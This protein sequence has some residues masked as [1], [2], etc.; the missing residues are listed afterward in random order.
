MKP[1]GHASGRGKNQ[2]PWSLPTSGLCSARGEADAPRASGV[3]GRPPAL[4]TWELASGP[5]AGVVVTEELSPVIWQWQQRI[6]VPPPYWTVARGKPEPSDAGRRQSAGALSSE[7]WGPPGL[8]REGLVGSGPRLTNQCAAA[9]MEAAGALGPECLP[10]PAG[11][12]RGSCD[13]PL[14]LGQAPDPAAH[15]NPTCHHRTSPC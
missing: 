2:T 6:P 10:Q 13:L 5:Q 12:F 8:P 11:P 7:P 9:D 4:C 1:Q 3:K 14:K 15:A